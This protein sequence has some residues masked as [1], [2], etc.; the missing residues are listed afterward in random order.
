MIVE[1]VI[2]LV[3]MLVAS[4]ATAT[5]AEIATVP[6]HSDLV[7]ATADQALKSI[8]NAEESG[9]DVSGLVDRFNVAVDLQQRVERNDY[10]ACPSYDAC[11][12][13][14]NGILLSIVEDASSL[15]NEATAQREQATVLTF[16]VYLPLSSFIAAV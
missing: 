1:W 12:I 6:I 9:A 2:F 10:S 16:T 11:L 14:A 15:R 3:G 7:K 8:K 5:D 4:N 13:Q